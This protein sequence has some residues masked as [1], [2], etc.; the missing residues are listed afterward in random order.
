MNDP[1]RTRWFQVS[2]FL[3]GALLA[4]GGS[5]LWNNPKLEALEAVVDER[6][7]EERDVRTE[8]LVNQQDMETKIEILIDEVRRLR[9]ALE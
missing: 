5:S 8:I 1:G 7:E 2:I 9:D 3:A 4:G 6:H